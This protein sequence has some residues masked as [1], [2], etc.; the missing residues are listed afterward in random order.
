MI[1][2]LAACAAAAF[3]VLVALS[4]PARA[5]PLPVVATFSI[6][7]QIAETI[8]GDKIRVQTL[9]GPD[10]DAHVYQPTPQDSRVLAEARVVL[11]NGLGFEGWIERLVK[12]SGTKA[13]V[14][15]AT[16]GI[17]SRKM[18]DAHGHGSGVDP[19]VWHDP[20]RMIAYVRNLAEGLAG[21]DPANAETYRAAGAALAGRLEALDSWAEA[22]FARV[23]AAKRKVITT[24]DAFG[25]LAERYKLT[26]R[27]PRGLTTDAEPS[28][29]GIARLIDQI[30]AEKIRALFVENITDRRMIDQL[31]KEAGAVVGGRLYSDAL[32]AADGPAATYE[33]L[34][35]HNVSLLTSGMLQN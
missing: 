17:P 16:R 9:V 32:S 26:F 18:T 6:L 3:L 27:S 31:G 13:A 14:V 15:T 2:L 29:K 30:R 10:R 33:A 34:F 1:R 24:H 21:A 7:G 35:R 4:A 5:E 20:R 11:V 19:H 12:A 22:E 8:G 23:P 25:Y 28:A